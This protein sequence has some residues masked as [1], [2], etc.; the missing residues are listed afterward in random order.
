MRYTVTVLLP[1]DCQSG[2]QTR[3][4]TAGPVETLP[5]KPPLAGLESVS[6]KDFLT[7]RSGSCNARVPAAV[8]QLNLTELTLG[9]FHSTAA[10]EAFVDGSRWGLSLPGEADDPQHVMPAPFNDWKSP[11]EIFSVCPSDDNWLEAGLAAGVHKVTLRVVIPGGLPGPL[12]A[13]IEVDLSCPAEPPEESPEANVPDDVPIDSADGSLLQD[14]DLP[15]ADGSGIDDVDAAPAEALVDDAGVDGEAL[16]AE[17]ESEPTASDSVGS[18][19]AQAKSRPMSVLVLAVVAMAV[20]YRW[21][22]RPSDP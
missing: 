2:K 19:S 1:N 21:R 6:V 3:H 5:D 12:S 8:A 7:S 20:A 9:G 16:A 11:L 10:L 22:R 13:P 15:A 18:C 17:P 4:F 14:A